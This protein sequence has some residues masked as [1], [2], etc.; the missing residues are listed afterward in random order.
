[1]ILDNTLIE[2][3]EE[4]DDDGDKKKKK[5]KN[6]YLNLWYNFQIKHISTKHIT[7]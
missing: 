5:K 4:D 1:M 2:I 3:E 7:R 6:Y